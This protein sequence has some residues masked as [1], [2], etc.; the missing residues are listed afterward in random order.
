MDRGADGRASLLAELGL[1]DLTCH[2]VDPDSLAFVALANAALLLLL[3]FLC[4]FERAAAAPVDRGAR[5][6]SGLGTLH[7]AVSNI[8]VNWN[9]GRKNSTG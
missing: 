5:E 6:G 1:A 8:W 9:L 7:S 3:H 2:S 4:R